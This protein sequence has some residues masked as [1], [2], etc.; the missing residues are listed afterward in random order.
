[1]SGPQ[2]LEREPQRQF[3][4]PRGIAPTADMFPRLGSGFTRFH[5]GTFQPVG[6]KVL[7]ET[8]IYPFAKSTRTARGATTRAFN[9][10]RKYAPVTGSQPVMH[11]FLYLIFSHAIV[12]GT[13]TLFAPD[14]PCDL[15]GD[16]KVYV[17]GNRRLTRYEGD[18]PADRILRSRNA[19]GPSRARRI[20]VGRRDA[21]VLRAME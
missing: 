20:V 12:K 1:M 17:Q 3:A 5:E 8:S 11:P 2:K 14:T 13:C 18:G 16:P 10:R 6:Y 7:S 9:E 4:S 19:R 21:N 15:G